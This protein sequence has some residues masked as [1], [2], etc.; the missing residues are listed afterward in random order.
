VSGV[1]SSGVRRKSF[2]SSS[3]IFLLELDSSRSSNFTLES[4]IYHCF[5]FSANPRILIFE[6]CGSEPTSPTVE[7][8]GW[9]AFERGSLSKASGTIFLA[10]IQEIGCQASSVSATLA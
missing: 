3:L 8:L 4:N 6:S 7:E 9:L 5:N 10:V 2:N 1:R